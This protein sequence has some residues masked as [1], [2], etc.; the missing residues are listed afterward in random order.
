MTNPSSFVFSLNVRFISTEEDL[1]SSEDGFCSVDFLVSASVTDFE[2]EV[3][4]KII[5]K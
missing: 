2:E 5:M 3:L 1:V 4:L